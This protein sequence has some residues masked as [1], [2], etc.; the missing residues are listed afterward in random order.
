MQKGSMDAPRRVIVVASSATAAEALAA[1]RFLPQPT[2]LL[3]VVL[4]TP[5]PLRCDVPLLGLTNDLPEILRRCRPQHVFVWLPVALAH[6]S[7]EL[8]RLLERHAVPCSFHTPIAEAVQRPEAPSGVHVPAHA[9]QP[10]LSTP[11][12]VAKLVG[13]S[14]RPLDTALAQPL[15]QGARVLI[16]GAGGSI[17]S[18]LA[19]LCAAL[20]P[21]EIILMERAENALFEIDRQ[22]SASHADLARRAILHD[23]AEEA[24]TRRIFQRVRPDVVFHA[25]AHKHVPLMEDHPVQAVRNN[26]LGAVASAQAAIDAGARRFVLIST[27][28]AVHPRS[29]MGATKRLAELA[30]RRLHERARAAGRRTL[31]RMVRFGNVLGSNCSVL[32]I[33]EKQLAEG[34]PLTVTDPRMTRYFMTIPE[35]AALVAQAAALSEEEAQGA[36]LFV[37]DMGKPVR[38]LDLAMRFLRQR[39]CT[40][41]LEGPLHAHAASL[42]PSAAKDASPVVAVRI[43]G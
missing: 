13:R 6:E 17:G 39:G 16:T 23:V 14:P 42:S 11:V 22:L 10:A 41:R 8:R 32:P 30:V 2:Q 15:I 5:A 35:A 7:L 26:A 40:P 1:L 9:M 19:R 43:V 31:L 34:G 37:L 36:D 3:G 12:D 4:T 27:D 28:K 18:E 25:A 20:E 21:A 38:I 29:V 33:W 24:A